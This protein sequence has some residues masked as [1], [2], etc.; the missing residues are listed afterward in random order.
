VLQDRL[1]E[2]LDLTPELSFT[3]PVDGALHPA[4]RAG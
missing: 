1:C 2:D 3:G 4:A